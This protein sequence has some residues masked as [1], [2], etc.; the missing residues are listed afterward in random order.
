MLVKRFSEVEKKALSF[1]AKDA[2]CFQQTSVLLSGHFP[3]TVKIRFKSN[4]FKLLM[5]RKDFLPLKSTK[6]NL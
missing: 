2:G 4:L 5:D 6:S 1:V 3:N